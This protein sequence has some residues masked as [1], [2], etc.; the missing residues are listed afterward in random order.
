MPLDQT[1]R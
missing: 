1:C